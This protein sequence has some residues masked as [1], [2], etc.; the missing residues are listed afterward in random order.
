M[1]KEELKEFMYKVP[2]VEALLLEKD[3]FFKMNWSKVPVTPITPPDEGD[4]LSEKYPFST[5]NQSQEWF[6]FQN[7]KDQ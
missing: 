3:V 1:Y 7:T 2:P 4:E 6:H 5:T